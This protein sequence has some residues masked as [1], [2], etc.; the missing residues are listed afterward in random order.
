MNT[1]LAVVAGRHHLEEVEL[2]V[3]PRAV[4]QLDHESTLCVLA[5]DAA[6]AELA[7]FDPVPLL[8][9]WFVQVVRCAGGALGLARAGLL[10]LP[11]DGGDLGPAERCLRRCCRGY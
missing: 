10:G 5:I 3:L 9:H 6:E 11:G 7:M 1:A 2:D 4:R 8:Q